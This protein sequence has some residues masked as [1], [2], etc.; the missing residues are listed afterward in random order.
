MLRRIAGLSLG[1]LMGCAEVPSSSSDEPRHILDPLTS[2]ELSATIAVLQAEGYVS[3]AGLYPLITLD[4]PPKA[5]VR[6]WAP[7]DPLG[8]RRAFVVLK[9]GRQTFEGVV[10]LEA[11]QVVSWTEIEGVEPAF[12][13]SEEWTFVQRLVFASAEWREAMGRRGVTDLRHVVCV[14]KT[15]GHHGL[16]DERGRRLVKVVCYDGEGT[17]N[18]WGRP[19]EGLLAVVDLHSREVRVVDTGAVPIPR[20]PVDLYEA[21]VGGLRE[22]PRP[23]S[24]T[25]P[26]GP[27]FRVAGRLVEWQK[28]RFHVHLHPRTGLVIS[29]VDYEDEGERREILYQGS[30]SELFVPYMDPTIGWYFRTYLD[31]GEFGVGKLAVRL[32][33]EI[34]CPANARFF[35][36]VL[37]DDRGEPYTVERAICVFERYA[38]DIAWRHSEAANGVTEARRRTDLVVRSI[39]AIGNYDYVF[40]WTF[41]QDGVIRIAVGATGVEQV[42][43][44]AHATIAEG[45]GEESRDDLRYGRL[46]AEGTLAVNHDHF[47]S[48]RLDLDVD[49]PRNTFLHETLKTERTAEES[50]RSSVWVVESNRLATEG[51]AR[52]RIRLDEPALWRVIN[53]EVTG[54]VG[55]PVSYQLKPE[56][57]AVSLLSPDDPL[58]RRAGFTDYHLWVTP[59]DPAERYAAGAYPNQSAGGDGLASWTSADRPIEDAD[60]VLW[61][62]VGFHHVVRAEDWPVLPTGWSAF[63]LRPFDFFDRNPALD[64]PLK[65]WTAR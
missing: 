3:E 57:N 7:G 37:A 24:M 40:D 47:F 44:V 61:Y 11:R 52:L 16:P 8:P 1:L 49:G 4:E 19:I 43:A 18:Y 56:A 35:D 15:V 14:P 58:R 21:A 30:L 23:I 46:V 38:G 33:P 39:S 9:R 34:D 6:T 41:R 50:P 48:F 60:I 27:S 20:T 32:E 64:I 55:Y 63:E 12:L 13:L 36:A 42:K 51:A 29:T 10:D 59:H 45:D 65:P 31:A 28:W 2:G 26:D 22:P 25:Q 62:T 53:P 5:D 17:Y 54:P